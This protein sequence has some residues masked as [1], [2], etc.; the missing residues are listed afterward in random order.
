METSIAT[1]SLPGDL[2]EKIEA[3]AAAGFEGIEIFENDLLS[4]SG[5]AADVRKLIADNGLTLIAFQPFRDFEGMV[6]AQRDRAFSRAD[7]K[8]GLIGELGCDLLMVCSNVSPES[9]GGLEQAAA[10]FHELGERAKERGIRIGFEAMAWGLHIHDYRDSW[11]VV[12]RADH[13][14]VG[15]A[16]DSF[17]ICARQTDLNPIRRIP[18]E[19]IFLVQVSDA[20]LLDMNVMHWSRHF[21]CFPGQG[22]LPVDEFMDCLAATGYD[23][24][25]SLETF[26]DQFRAGSTRAVAIDGRRSLIHLLDRHARAGNTSPNYP[27]A[28]LPPPSKCNGAQ[29]IEFAVDEVQAVEL[30]RLFKS[31]GFSPAGTHV[32]K[33]VTRLKQGDIN[34]VINAEKDGFA[35]AYN[36]AHGPGVCALAL[37]VEDATATLDRAEA[38]LDRP[39]RQAVGPGELEIPAVRGLGGSLLYF[40]DD[41]G[42]LGRNWDI[43]FKP[44][45]NNA[46]SPEAGLLSVDHISQSMQ[47]EEMLSWL[48]F[49]GSLFDVEKS[50]EQD[51]SDPGGLVRSQVIQTPDGALRIILNSSQSNRTL[52]SRFLNEFVGSGVQHIAFATDDLVST[53][54]NLVANGVAI[55]P[56]PENYYDDLEARTDLPPERL[57]QLRTGNI[58]YDADEH[59]EYLQAYT[60]TFQNRFF[61]EFVE[62][63][64][65]KGFGAI[66][67]P[68]RLAAQTRLA[69]PASAIG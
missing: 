54:Q 33:T 48:L 51:V 2:R 21:R 9:Q 53:I 25:L 49:Y 59:G 39:F 63:R 15:I 6:G 55:L 23:D 64:G 65:Y 31:L 29:F 8:F 67:A 4:F 11:E 34:L 10:D 41:K 18:K 28:R 17:H 22:D 13:P 24:W 69:Q 37:K 19:K 16:L 1:V 3:I 43:D 12:R 7:R 61:F 45:P 50:K 57:K 47:Y 26:N 66:N 62:R 42:S 40:L 32:S 60:D 35:H 27:P 56:I 20:P 58:L 52:S 36:I 5:N 14:N 38:L 46:A 30:N 44:T 68:I